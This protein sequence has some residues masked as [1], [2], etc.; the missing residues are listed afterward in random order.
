MF[1]GIKQFQL[2]NILWEQ[3]IKLYI[4]IVVKGY[5]AVH[6]KCWNALCTDLYLPV[7]PTFRLDVQ[8]KRLLL[9]L[10][11]GHCKHKHLLETSDILQCC[12]LC[13]L[14]TRQIQ[15]SSCSVKARI[16][17][18]RLVFPLDLVTQIYAEAWCLV[19]LDLCHVPQ[20]SLFSVVHVNDAASINLFCI[21][22]ITET[23]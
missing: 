1:N 12:L 13:L 11:F 9:C 16:Q 3:T 17:I 8:R 18:S 14:R 20:F 15:P 19:S 2:Y 10:F 21:H 4:V 22:V 6:T 7:N 5:C 23:K